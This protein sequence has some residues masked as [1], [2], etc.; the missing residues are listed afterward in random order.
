MAQ[1]LSVSSDPD[2]AK[3]TQRLVD[4]LKYCKEVLL[5]IRT[6][7]AA[8]GSGVPEESEAMG[9]A[10]TGGATA[11]APSAAG[12]LASRASKMSLR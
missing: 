9:N 12:S 8:G 2:Q 11:S 1:S 5:S 4:K 6:A 7:S 3:F 10:L